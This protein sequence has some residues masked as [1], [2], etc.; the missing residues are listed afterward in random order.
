[1]EDAMIVEMLAKR[2]M[3]R[4]INAVEHKDLAGVLRFSTPDVV[5]EMPAGGPLSGEWRGRDQVRGLF[6]AI[7]GHNAALH[8][9]LR[10][11]AVVHGWSPTGSM[12]VFAEVDMEQRG[13]DGD[14]LRVTAVTSARP[15]GG[16]RL[17][18][19]CTSR[20]YPP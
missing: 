1:L 9:S 8:Y 10:D 14:L 19:A 2:T 7:F 4:F 12:K 16:R 20:T 3:T 13:Y 6:A 5:V 18:S 15:V 17:G 11:L